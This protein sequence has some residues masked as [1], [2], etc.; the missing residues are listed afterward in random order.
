M[1]SR[2][3]P[4]PRGPLRSE[5]GDFATTRSKTFQAA[6]TRPASR[7]A[8]FAV[9]GCPSLAAGSAGT[10]KSV[11]EPRTRSTISKSSTVTEGNG[12]AAAFATST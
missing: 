11:A 9:I 6:P 8:S 7:A 12:M 5:A 1:T 10:P 2:S 3:R 4:P